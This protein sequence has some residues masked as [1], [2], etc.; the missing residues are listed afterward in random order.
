MF[1]LVCGIIDCQPEICNRQQIDICTYVLIGRI[2]RISGEYPC[3]RIL[4]TFTR[5]NYSQ[6]SKAWK[7]EC[8]RGDV[9]DLIVSQGQSVQI[10]QG[11]G[12]SIWIQ[13][14]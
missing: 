7:G 8:I 4:S 2:S 14:L 10:E 9:L 1:H 5:N 3:F 12:K 13:T 11:S 6:V